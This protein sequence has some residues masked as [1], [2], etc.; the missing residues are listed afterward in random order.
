MPDKEVPTKARLSL[1]DILEI[2]KL[3]D[4]THSVFTKRV[5]EV[6]TEFGPFIAKKN[7]TLHPSAV[8]PIKVF[9]DAESDLSEYY[10]DTVD[11]NECCWMMFIKPAD[12]VAEQNLICYQ[13]RIFILGYKSI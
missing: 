1:P 2:K 4:E 10:L 13:V 6:G 12:D 5:V 11:E 3:A 9:N 7:L 8:F